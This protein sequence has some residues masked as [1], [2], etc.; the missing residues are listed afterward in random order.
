V[1]G[2]EDHDLHHSGPQP[3]VTPLQ[4][5]EEMDWRARHGQSPMNVLAEAI[6]LCTAAAAT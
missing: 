2:E 4:Q 1:T 5:G 6:A 3:Q